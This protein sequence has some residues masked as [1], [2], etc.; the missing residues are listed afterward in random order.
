MLVL[1]DITTGKFYSWSAKQLTKLTHLIIL[2]KL[3]ADT[4]VKSIYEWDFQEIFLYYSQNAFIWMYS[5]TVCKSHNSG[6]CIFWN[7]F[8]YAILVSKFSMLFSFTFQYWSQ[9]TIL[10]CPLKYHLEL[11]MQWLCSNGLLCILTV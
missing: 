7:I 3:I 10:I 5:Y 9:L 6:I 1:S 8:I 2:T 4:M 11:L